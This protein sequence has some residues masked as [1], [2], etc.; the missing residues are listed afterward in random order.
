MKRNRR[1]KNR[2]ILDVVDGMLP[3]I[4]ASDLNRR[5]GAIKA[6]AALIAERAPA[7]AAPAW[8]EEIEGA[9]K[10]RLPRSIQPKDL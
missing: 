2:I 6:I 3:W 5:A 7:A 9:A 4:M 10:L 8:R 1:N